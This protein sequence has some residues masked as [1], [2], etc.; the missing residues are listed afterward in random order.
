MTGKLKAPAPRSMELLAE[1][2]RVGFNDSHYSRLHHFSVKPGR[3][4]DTISKHLKYLAERGNREVWD[5]NARLQERLEL[6]LTMKR[7]DPA[8]DF[9]EL[10]RRAIAAVPFVPADYLA[11]GGGFSGD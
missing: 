6:V 7:R 1:L 11:G 8:A 2:Q 3:K 4:G 10:G 5:S 9:D